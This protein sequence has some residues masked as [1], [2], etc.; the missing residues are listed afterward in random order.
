VEEATDEMGGSSDERI[1]PSFKTQ[2]EC[3][4]LL[5]LR[6]TG[7][8]V[9]TIMQLPKGAPRLTVSLSL[10]RIGEVSSAA[11]GPFSGFTAPAL[12]GGDRVYDPNVADAY[13]PAAEPGVA[14]PKIWLLGKV[15]APELAAS[16]AGKLGLVDVSVASG[17]HQNP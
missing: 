3:A 1:C 16:L 2:M 17:E 5:H 14:P 6:A 7:A 10:A 8:S 4:S 11:S 13:N 12:G 15:G 9:E